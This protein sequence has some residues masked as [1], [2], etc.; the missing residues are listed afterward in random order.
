MGQK[1]K[2]GQ[3]CRELIEF[4]HRNIIKKK[5]LL[6]GCTGS[7]LVSKGFPTRERERER[8]NL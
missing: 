1:R 4:G 2:R 5:T 8:E 6:N 7:V 3:H